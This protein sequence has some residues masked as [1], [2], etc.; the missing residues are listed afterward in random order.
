MSLAAA[1]SSESEDPDSPAGPDSSARRDRLW[2]PAFTRLV[3]AQ[4]FFGFAYSVFLLLPKLLAVA[5]GAA[6]Q[7]IGFVMAAF[8]ALSLAS[9]PAVSPVVARLGRRDTMT[10]GF[11]LLA[12]SALAFLLIRRADGFAALLRGLQGIAWSLFFAAGMSLLPGPA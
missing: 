1:P 9:I 3:I 12:G 10:T 5:Y 6:A 11:A 7:E 4:A 8:G 2:T